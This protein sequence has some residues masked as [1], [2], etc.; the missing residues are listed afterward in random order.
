MKGAQS[1][2]AFR[3]QTLKEMLLNVKESKK[4]A[5]YDK[6]IFYCMEAW[7]VSR[8]TARDYMDSILQSD[9]MKREDIKIKL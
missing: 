9:F 4:I 1:T 6:L 2:R 7:M 3:I 5:D 8:R